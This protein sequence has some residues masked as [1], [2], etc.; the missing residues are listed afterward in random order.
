MA[1][2]YTEGLGVELIGSGDKAGS[3]GDVTN[4]NL[5][6]LEEG[7]SRYAEI[8]VTGA[9]AD[10]DIPDASTAYS[11]DS[12]GRSS[13]I[14]WTGDPSNSTHTVTLKVGNNLRTQAKFTAVNSLTSPASLIISCGVGSNVTIPNGYSADVHIEVDSVGAAT[15]VVNSLSSL[16]I[17]KLALGNQ[18]VISNTVDDRVDIISPT[19]QVG[20]GVDNSDTIIQAEAGGA[21]AGRDLV[22]RNNARGSAG[23]IRFNDVG[24][25]PIEITPGGTG[26]VVMPKVTISDGTIAGTVITN[27]SIGSSSP[28]TG[29]FTSLGASGTS[30]LGTVNAAAIGGT[31]I[32]ASTGLRATTGGLV[33]SAGGIIS[34]GNTNLNSG[35]ITLAGS[36]S[37]AS[38][39]TASGNIISDS[40]NLQASNG[41]LGV[42]RSAGSAGP[43]NIS[44]IGLISTSGNIETTGSGTISSAGRITS[45]GGLNTGGSITGATDITASGTATANGF[46]AQTSG[47]LINAGGLTVNGT[48]NLNNGGITNAGALS[49]VTTVNSG[50]NA[51]T[52]GGQV[53]AGSVDSTGTITSGGL[54][55]DAGTLNVGNRNISNAGS[56][57][58]ATDITASGTVSVVDL[59]ASGTIT[60]NVSGNIT[61]NVSGNAGSVTNGVYTTNKINVLAATSSAELAGVISDETGTGSLVF[62]NSPTFVTPALGTPSALVGTNISGTAAN[63]TAGTATT[64]PS[65]SGDVTSSGN[66]VT[67]AND[68]VGEAKLSAASPQNDY[69]LVADDAVTGGLKWAENTAGDITGVNG[70]TNI[71]VTSG[72]GPVPNVNLDSAISLANV[73]TSSKIIV[74]ADSNF[75]TGTPY[76]ASQGGVRSSTFTSRVQ[77]T[78]MSISPHGTGSLNLSST[79]T[80]G[81]V[82][83]VN[84]KCSTAPILIEASSSTAANSIIIF[85]SGGSATSD[86]KFVVQNTGP[87]IPEPSSGNHY[88]NFSDAGGTTGTGLRNSTD[89]TLEIRSKNSS[90]ADGWGRAY[91]SGMVSGD[92]A[93][94]QSSVN[95][96]SVGSGLLTSNFSASQVHAGFTTT[97]KIIRCVIRCLTGQYNW[98]PGDE[99]DVT[100]LAQVDEASGGTVSETIA[101]GADTTSLYVACNRFERMQIPNRNGGVGGGLTL[102]NWDIYMYAWK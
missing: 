71:T 33:V 85:R 49:S 69:V 28:S 19:L 65:L 59:D 94:F 68:V 56:I 55:L 1:S 46:V 24:S 4:N 20:A 42:G 5:Q 7:I 61:G 79:G 90:T 11:T 16:S 40:G 98:V 91:H 74:G 67:I 10:L 26:S 95:L 43:G 57:T 78:S 12:K 6:A 41:N 58:G 93:F 64:I 18:E 8:A 73:T 14:K 54:T 36:I 51:V 87:R 72:A 38:S 102:A 62:A 44:A 13:V 80:A 52:F 2:D 60:G 3:W 100:S 25:G 97:P 32:T 53:N 63:L 88:L 99:V 22:I 9:A 34:N 29:A 101:F 81:G 92:G 75:D 96:G 50:G 30:T 66:S 47:L 77:N 86:G 35:G 27:S 83:R 23:S 76:I 84:I 21:N 17:D 15:G 37:G 70:G 31:L 39:I 82:P 48:T 45:S 89:G